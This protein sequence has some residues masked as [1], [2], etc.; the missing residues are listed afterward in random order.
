MKNIKL[1]TPCGILY[2]LLYIIF[3][4][5]LKLLFRL[6]VDKSNYNKPKGAFI[7]IANHSSFMDFLLAMLA[8]YPRRLNAVTA[9]K[10]FAVPILRF[11]FKIMGA[12]PK[13]LFEP[14]IRTIIGMK[15]T[16]TRGGGVLLFP[17]GRCSVDGAY[18]G[19][20]KSTAKLIKNLGVPVVSCVIGGSY[21]TMPFW[22]KGVKFGNLSV[23]ISTLFSEN[24][25]QSLSLDEINKA[26]DQSLGSTDS[27]VSNN[28]YRTFSGKKLAEG[29]HNILYWC[30]HCNAE[31]TTNTKGCKIYCISCNSTA[32]MDK[33]SKLFAENGSTFPTSIHEWFK[34]Q[35][36]HE[37]NM[38][39]EDMKP[40]EVEVT[41]RTPLCPNFNDNRIRDSIGLLALSSQGWHYEGTIMGEN[42]SHSFPIE[43]V[44]AL[45]FDPAQNFQIYSG[46]QYYEFIPKNLQSC[47]KYSII[48]ECAHWRF[49]RRVRMTP[50]RSLERL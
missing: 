16:V 37:M 2:F 27:T 3:Y 36:A 45:P 39:H 13:N 14:D 33:Y 10:F 9:Q 41:V 17:E 6:K 34:M 12:M 4:P 5:I 11:L 20:N 25:T 46:G 18:M 50:S 15:Q 43:T 47:A 49:S 8:I 24:E 19:I 38:L 31:F 23:T 44:P 26:L 22:R 29:L 1:R 40:I 7:V 42:V 21:T 28:R 32:S 35:T 48:G 30:P